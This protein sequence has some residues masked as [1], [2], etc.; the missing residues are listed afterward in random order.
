[1]LEDDDCVA[2]QKDDHVLEDDACGECICFILKLILDADTVAELNDDDDVI[3]LLTTGVAQSG[4]D[5][6]SDILSDGELLFLLV[7]IHAAFDVPIV[8]YF[9]ELNDDLQV[10]SVSSLVEKESLAVAA[11]SPSKMEYSSLSCP[12]PL[13]TQKLGQKRKTPI[14]ESQELPKKIFILPPTVGSATGG[15]L[16]CPSTPF[17]TQSNYKTLQGTSP[18]SA[19]LIRP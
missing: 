17:M 4:D 6:N 16:P 8:G 10:G 18:M 9:D 19:V 1:V 3:I 7:V 13:P 14:L 11:H 2:E 15:P 12:T 5:G